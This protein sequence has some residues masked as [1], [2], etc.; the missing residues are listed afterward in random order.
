MKQATGSNDRPTRTKRVSVQLT[1]DGHFFSADAREAC[2]GAE[3]VELLTPATLLVP[4]PQ[5]DPQHG[6][7]LFAAAGL[8]LAEGTEIV[9]ASAGQSD[10]EAEELLALIAVDGATR[11]ALEELCDA[12]VRYTTPLLS[13]VKTKEPVVRIC[14]TEHVLYI[15]LFDAGLQLAEAIPVETE[16]DR[17]YL[18]ERLCERIDPKRFVLGLEDRSGCGRLYRNRFKKMIPCA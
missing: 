3:E 18:L 6:A 17:L 4:R 16:Q 7:A 12:G 15:R 11:Q 14:D 1:L 13:P 8:P 10:D 2:R 5:F 9:T